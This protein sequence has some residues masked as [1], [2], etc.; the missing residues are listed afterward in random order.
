M[1][2]A[3][4]T[5]SRLRRAA[6]RRVRARGQLPQGAETVQLDPAD[7]TTRIDNP[8]WPMRPGSR[9]VYRETDP[10]GTRQKVVVTVTRPR[11]S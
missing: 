11:R 6:A 10:D 4:L 1:L 2:P 5:T 3:V 9:W 8:Y 7:F